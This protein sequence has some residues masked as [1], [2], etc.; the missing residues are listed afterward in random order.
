MCNRL[1]QK[2]YQSDY[3]LTKCQNTSFFDYWLHF[4]LCQRTS[5][6]SFWHFKKSFNC[7]CCKLSYFNLVYAI[8]SPFSSFIESTPL[9]SEWELIILSEV[10]LCELVK[11]IN[12]N[13]H[14]TC[15]SSDISNCKT[16]NKMSWWG[17]PGTNI[18]LSHQPSTS[19]LVPIEM[20]KA[21]KYPE[22]NPT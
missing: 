22:K 6:I 18:N 1:K 11:P 19:N 8:F 4:S 3:L 14:F 17:L 5:F 16:Y 15:H 20:I 7:I 21:P 10:V 13:H 9:H 2:W 12:I